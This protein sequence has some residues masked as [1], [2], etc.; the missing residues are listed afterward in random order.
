[1]P[2]TPLGIPTPADTVK[3]SQLALAVRNAAN[4]I[5]E[6]MATGITDGME[7]AAADAVA[8]IIGA[9]GFRLPGRYAKV[10]LAGGAMPNFTS[11]G[12][13][14]Y[15]DGLRVISGRDYYTVAPGTLDFT[16]TASAVQLTLI[17]LNPDTNLLIAVASTGLNSSHQHML[18]VA[19]FHNVVGRGR[20]AWMNCPFTYNGAYL[21]ENELELLHADEV[22]GANV[23]PTF[24]ASG[25]ISEIRHQI[26]GTTIRFDQITYSATQIVQ[27][28]QHV[29]TG[30]TITLTTNLTT[31]ITEVS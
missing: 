12:V 19:T 21:M 4:K 10:L 29:P 11:A 9:P 16:G 20:S 18:L 28:R 5:D 22:P 31:L 8:A 1:M 7:Q 6:I 17:L 2:T 30:R 13:M 23:V 24:N 26:G 14:T 3:I 15:P 25:D 27:V